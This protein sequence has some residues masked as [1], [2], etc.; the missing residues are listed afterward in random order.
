MTLKSDPPI[1]GYRKST[2][3]IP[4]ATSLKGSPEYGFEKAL[5]NSKP[6]NFYKPIPVVTAGKPGE[7]DEFRPNAEN[8]RI[9]KGVTVKLVERPGHTSFNDWLPN[10]FRREHPP[11]SHGVDHIPMGRFPGIAGQRTFENGFL[12]SLQAVDNIVGRP[13]PD[14]IKRYWSLALESAFRIPIAWNVRCFGVSG[15]FPWVAGGLPNRKRS[16][17]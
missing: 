3:R 14:S 8:H 2:D 11:L 13:N 16:A 17:G 4:G 7:S 15:S 10:S 1:I 5:I 6:C 9:K 12:A